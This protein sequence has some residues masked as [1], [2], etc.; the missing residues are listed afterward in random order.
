MLTDIEK[1]IFT[2][3]ALLSAYAA[4]QVGKRIWL[5][6]GRGQ[7]EL[8]RDNMSARVR[9]AL[10]VFVTQR[11]VLKRRPLASVAHLLVAWGF[12]LYLL[13]NVIDGL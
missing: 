13:V 2:V 6:V 3:L 5:V 11:T 1:I 7:G 9:R 8:G 10:G 4:Y 12:T